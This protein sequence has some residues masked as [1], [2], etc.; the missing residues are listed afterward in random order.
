MTSRL[1]VLS[2]TYPSPTICLLYI[3]GARYGTRVQS[4]MGMPVSVPTDVTVE[5]QGIVRSQ[6]YLPDDTVEWVRRQQR[7]RFTVL[8]ACTAGDPG[9]IERLKRPTWVHLEHCYFN[10]LHCS[11]RLPTDCTIRNAYQPTIDKLIHMGRKL[12]IEFRGKDPH[13]R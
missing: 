6:S 9:H 1:S 13:Q 11:Q 12:A 10:R 4:D 7:S 5:G 2:P 3:T 8:T